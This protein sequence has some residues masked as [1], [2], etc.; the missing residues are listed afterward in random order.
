MVVPVAVA[1]GEDLVA[2]LAVAVGEAAAPGE[3]VAVAPGDAVGA[4]C[5]ALPVRTDE[6]PAPGV[7]LIFKPR[8]G[9]G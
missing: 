8:A 6:L 3:A 1:V 9:F 4:V 7:T 5:P 2:G